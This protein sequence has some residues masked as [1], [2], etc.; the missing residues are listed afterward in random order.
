[1]NRSFHLVIE[2]PTAV[3]YGRVGDNAWGHVQFPAIYHTVNGNILASW[4]YCSDT[5]E[6]KGSFHSAVS[7][8]GGASWRDPAPT[9][10]IAY[11]EMSNGKYFAGFVR[12]GAYTVDYFDK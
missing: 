11:P 5:I 3:A 9:D 2:E 7:A 8:D 6:Y 12:K 1:M 4:E 10:R